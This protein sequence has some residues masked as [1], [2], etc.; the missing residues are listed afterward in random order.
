MAKNT[1][2]ISTRVGA[3]VAAGE[4]T[5]QT[6]STINLSPFALL[7]ELVTEGPSFGIRTPRRWEIQDGDPMQ[8]IDSE[9]GE[10]SDIS[11]PGAWALWVEWERATAGR[12]ALAWAHR[13]RSD[14]TSRE[15]LWAALLDAR[16]TDAEATDE[17]LAARDV[18][19][20]TLGG[21]P[22]EAWYRR[23]VWRPSLMA[24]VL[25]VAEAQGGAGVRDLMR[26]HGVSYDPRPEM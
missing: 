7:G 16:G 4:L 19:G 26:E 6:K 3:E 23:L 9:T 1:Y 22:R 24:Q 11:P 25:D 13:P 18:G 20:K 12:R 15:R 14:E 10:V 21:V 8:L 2:D 5:K 17:D